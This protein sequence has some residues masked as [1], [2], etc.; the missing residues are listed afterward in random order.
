MTTVRALLIFCFALIGTAAHAATVI[1]EDVPEKGVQPQVLT[2]ADGTVH[3]VYLV[4]EMRNSD[5]RYTRRQGTGPWSPAVTVNSEAGSAIAGGTIRGA[6]MALGKDGSVQVLWNGHSAEAAKR[7]KPVKSPLW[8]ARLAPGAS[9]FTPQQDLMSDS[10]ALDGGASIAASRDGRVEV[11]WHG[12]PAGAEPAEIRR[13]VLARR[14]TDDGLTFA[15]PKILNVDQPGVCACCSLRAH[16]DA[17]GTLSVL[18]RAAKAMDDRPMTLLT[19]KGASPATLQTLETW[20]IAACPMSSATFMESPSG[21]RGAWETEKLVRTG[22]VNGKP[23]TWTKIGPD[24]AK[25]P[26][27]AMNPQGETLITLVGGSGW[28]KGGKL[29][30]QLLDAQ[31]R[32]ASSGA[33][34]ATPVWSFAAPYALKDGSFVILR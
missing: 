26:A 30:W 15:A 2:T 14:S 34:A 5:V 12:L 4:G 8:H 9:S 31:G 19:Q 11:V 21:L 33:G 27:M 20:R 32:P 18:F 23:E 16:L 28:A 22:P 29:H 17:T 3:L 24:N 10:L 13:V 1:E 25:H 6:Q 7:G